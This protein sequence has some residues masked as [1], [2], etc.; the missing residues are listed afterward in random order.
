MA[1]PTNSQLSAYD[2]ISGTHTLGDQLG[3]RLPGP[4]QSRQAELVGVLS[5]QRDDL[6]L[7][8]CRK[9]GLLAGAAAAASLRKRVPAAWR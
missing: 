2:R 5:H 4:Q 6:L 1:S 7:L 9:G 3:D 8:A